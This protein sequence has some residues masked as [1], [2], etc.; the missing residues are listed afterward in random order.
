MGTLAA[1]LY[2][3][4]YLAWYLS[5]DI[6]NRSMKYF[7]KHIVVDAACAVLTLYITKGISLVGISYVA[8]IIMALKVAVTALAV[9]LAIN[10]V[11][12]PNYIKALFRM[13]FGFVKSLRSKIVNMFGK[14]KEELNVSSKEHIRKE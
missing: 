14:S 5:K 13:V 1:M 7:F 11:L 8:W 6:L 3:T 12:Y 10:C 9:N 4:T 2:R